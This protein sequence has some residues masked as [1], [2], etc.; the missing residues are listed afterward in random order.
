MH[1]IVQGLRSGS[2]GGKAYNRV[3]LV[4]HSTGSAVAAIEANTY[5]DVDGLILTGWGHG[6]P[7]AMSKF[8]GWSWH[9]LAREDPKCVAG[10]SRRGREAA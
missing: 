8:K 6:I 7:M 1:Q 4:G 9:C 2:I 5:E 10:Q 3:V